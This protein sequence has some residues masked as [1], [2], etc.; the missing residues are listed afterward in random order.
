[1]VSNDLGNTLLEYNVRG[2]HSG[3]WCH[4]SFARASLSVAVYSGV[5]KDELRLLCAVRLG[6]GLRQCCFQGCGNLMCLVTFCL[7]IVV[8]ASSRVMGSFWKL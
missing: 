8:V 6:R 3:R 2:F 1:M 5:S 7:F 4:L